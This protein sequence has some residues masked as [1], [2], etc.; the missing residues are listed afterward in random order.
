MNDDREVTC[1]ALLT[2]HLAGQDV[3]SGALAGLVRA[4]ATW[5][6]AARC[7]RS[8]LADA[9]ALQA[10]DA[11]HKVRL[12]MEAN[13]PRAARAAA[14]LLNPAY[15]QDPGRSW[16][17]S[18]NAGWRGSPAHGKARPTGNCSCWR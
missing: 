6:T 1:Y 12:A 14:A 10:D 18:P 13:R 15:R 17:T 8:T 3:R 4:D 11:W 2:Q 16:P 5:T 7:W 9:G